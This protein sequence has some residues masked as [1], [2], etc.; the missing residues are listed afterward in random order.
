[1][2]DHAAVF[3]G[4][5]RRLTVFGESAGAGSILHLLASP[6]RGDVFDQAIVQSGE[7]RTLTEAEAALVAEALVRELGLATADASGLRSVALDRLLAAQARAA[8]ATFGAIGVMPFHPAIDGDLCDVSVLDGVHAGRA[9]AR[10]PGHR[11]HRDELSL[12][13]EPRAATLDEDGLARWVHR[14]LGDGIDARTVITTYRE[15]LG[16]TATVP[17][18]WDAVRTDAMMRI[19]N[20]RVADAHTAR[21]APTFVYRFDWEAPDVGAAHAVD[22]P[23]AFGTFDREGWDR[24]RRVRRGRRAARGDHPAGL[25]HVRRHRRPPAGGR[26]APARPRA[27]AD[28]A[29]RP[30][31]SRHG[32]RPGGRRP[33]LLRKAEQPEAL[34]AEAHGGVVA[35]A[36]E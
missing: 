5:P 7:P 29:A 10:G 21:G 14:L 16:A 4:D 15:Q 3:G 20:L 31:R 34:L 30:G 32:R 1:M 33:A 13:P 26:L 2:R 11:N 19:P 17:T 27:P 22:V 12:F 23:F 9:D 28:P 35:G 36:L 25:D 8:A 6:R 18:I 24:A